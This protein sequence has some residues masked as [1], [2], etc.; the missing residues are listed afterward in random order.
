[1]AIVQRRRS[2][3]VGRAMS[4]DQFLALP[5]RKPYL[6]YEDGVVI[7]KMPP[8]GE[9]STLQGAIVGV[10][11]QLCGPAKIAHAFPELRVTFGGKSYVPDVSVFAWERIERKPNGEV[12]TDFTTAPDIVMEIVS[13]RPSVTKLVARCSWYVA[14]G[15]RAAVLVDEKDRIILVFFPDRAAT[16]LRGDDD[17]G[18]DAVLPGLELTVSQVF[19]ALRL[20]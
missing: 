1:M 20:D 7:Q 5:E 16:A 2:S 10:V 15:A 12:A 9:H 17:L 11:N 13:P 8:K 18:L 14:N 3:L 4:L 6:E 19:G